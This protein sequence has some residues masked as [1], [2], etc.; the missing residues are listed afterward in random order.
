MNIHTPKGKHILIRIHLLVWTW[1]LIP[2]QPQG[3]VPGPEWRGK[4]HRRCNKQAQL[5]LR[6]L[7]SQTQAFNFNLMLISCVR[8]HHCARFKNFHRMTCVRTMDTTQGRLAERDLQD[9][10]I[11]KHFTAHIV[12]YLRGFQCMYPLFEKVAVV[13]SDMPFVIRVPTDVSA[14]IRP[15]YGRFHTHST[16]GTV[17]SHPINSWSLSTQVTSVSWSHQPVSTFTA[18]QRRLRLKS[19]HQ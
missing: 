11:L 18:R 6:C 3:T 13:S 16:Q 12:S 10:R 19:T 5:L 4:E 14:N 9:L 17:V 7:Q 15:A 1:N 8:N 2:W